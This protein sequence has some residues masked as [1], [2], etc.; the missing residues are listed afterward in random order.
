[1]SKSTALLVGLFLIALFGAAAFYLPDRTAALS[2]TLTAIVALVSTYIGFQVANN[3][4]KGHW[5]NPDM[6]D[7]ENKQKE[8]GSYDGTKRQNADGAGPAG[9]T[10][11]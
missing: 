6:F 10:K 2:P 5:W 11:V 1:M 8:G 4:V 9:P 7:S 3:G